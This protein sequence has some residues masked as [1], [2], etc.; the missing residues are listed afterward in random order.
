MKMNFGLL[1]GRQQAVSPNPN[2]DST[3]HT[4][5]TSPLEHAHFI[6]NALALASPLPHWC[7][8]TVPAGGKGE[9]ME[10]CATW[11]VPLYRRQEIRDLP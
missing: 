8:S 10:V 6:G 5:R 4:R 7:N 3:R 1:W 11:P 9:R 2:V